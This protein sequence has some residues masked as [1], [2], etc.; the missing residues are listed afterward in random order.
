MVAYTEE[1]LRLQSCCDVMEADDYQIAWF[2]RGLKYDI[3]DKMGVQPT[4]SLIDAQ[5]MALQAES[6]L[7]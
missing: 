1:F 3:Q 2:V 7:A 6:L 4:H 5:E